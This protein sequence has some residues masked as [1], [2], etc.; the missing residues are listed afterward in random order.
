MER[1]PQSFDLQKSCGF[2]PG[3]IVEAIYIGYVNPISLIL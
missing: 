2:K 1:V 3:K